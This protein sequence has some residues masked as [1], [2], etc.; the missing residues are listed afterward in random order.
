MDFTISFNGTTILSLHDVSL[1]KFPFSLSLHF[2]R[3]IKNKKYF[4]ILNKPNMQNISDE[5]NEAWEKM[6]E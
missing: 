4:K 5:A 2:N 1:Y 6:F 3:D